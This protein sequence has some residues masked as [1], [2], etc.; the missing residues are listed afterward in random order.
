LTPD[1][2]DHLRGKLRV[3]IHRDLEVT[4]AVGPDRPR[5]SQAFCSALPVAYSRVPPAHW[6]PFASL[7]LEAAVEGTAGDRGRICMNFLHSA[8]LSSHWLMISAYRMNVTVSVEGI[9][10]ASVL[11]EAQAFLESIGYS[12]RWLMSPDASLVVARRES[13]V[14]CGLG[15]ATVEGPT[16]VLMSFAVHPDARSQGIGRRMVEALLSNLSASGARTVYLFSTVSG[17]FWERIGFSRAPI[18]EVAAKARNHFQVREYLV[19][20]TIWTD[21]AY[22]RTL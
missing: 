19:A 10:R 16:V 7:V 5:V 18:E 1:R 17:G 14:L 6:Q 20:G 12:T 21:T 4:A 3:G 8:Q 15:V 13:G 11:S 9:P 22:R 2:I